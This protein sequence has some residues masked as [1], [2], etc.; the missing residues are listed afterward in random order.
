MRIPKNTKRFQF[1]LSPTD[2]AALDALAELSGKTK[3]DALKY[4]IHES[5]R[6]LKT[7]KAVERLIGNEQN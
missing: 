1:R 3:T 7:A 6:I 4:A 5:L 2:L